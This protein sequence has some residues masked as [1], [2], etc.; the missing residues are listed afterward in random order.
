[1]AR[2]PLRERLRGQLMLA[3]YRSG[4]QAEALDGYRR[5]RAM[6]TTELGIE[7]SPALRELERR[8]LQQDP[9]LEL[10]P[11]QAPAA[12]IRR[13]AAPLGRPAAGPLR[14]GRTRAWSPLRRAC[15]VGCAPAERASTA[16]W[17]NYGH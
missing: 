8:M 17:T 11:P 14:L 10:A 1:M 5:L 15:P 13:P 2:H 6:L 4:R 16:R 12:P 7:P 3:L 9:R